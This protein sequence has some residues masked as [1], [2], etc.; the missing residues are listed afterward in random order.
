MVLRKER[1]Q[2]QQTP[3]PPHP[4]PLSEEE[5]GGTTRSHSGWTTTVW[6]SSARTMGRPWALFTEY[7]LGGPVLSV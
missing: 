1:Q 6:S 5:T 3:T 7:F 2:Q 4:I